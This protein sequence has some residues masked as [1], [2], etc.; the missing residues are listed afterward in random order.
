LK[1]FVIPPNAHLELSR[2]GSGGFFALG[3]IYRSN[4]QYAAFV[5]EEQ[6]RGRHIILDSG[7]GDHNPITQDELF[8]LT[9]EVMPTEVIPL[10]TLFDM[11]ATLQNLD[12]F[13]DRL[14]QKGL[15]GKI[16]I[17]ACPQGKSQEEWLQCYTTM[18]EHPFVDTIG[19]SKLAVPK[20]WSSY[21]DDQGIMEA[22]HKCIEFLKENNLLK[23]PLH[24]LGMGDPNE[25]SYYVALS[26]YAQY[27]DIFRS[28]DSCNSVFSGI[29]DRRWT[30]GNF[31][32]TKTPHDYFDKVMT[33]HQ[34]MIA[35][36]NATWLSK[37][38]IA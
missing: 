30:K 33:N 3:Q 17:F 16:K 6:K 15:L 7:I 5:Q 8:D 37:L 27:S 38:L 18:L 28:T 14:D 34:K 13:V 19:M 20:A 23:K 21:Q 2:L 25:F 11:K 36:E 31:E 35:I 4:K 12:D 9:L 32:R 22:R 26:K 29:L 1:N 24:F 10:D